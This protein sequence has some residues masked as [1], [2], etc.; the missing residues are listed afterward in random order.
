[1][2]LRWFVLLRFIQDWANQ[3]SEYKHVRKTN[4]DCEKYNNL[5][6]K[7][8]PSWIINVFV[9]MF[10]FPCLGVWFCLMY[11]IYETLW[12]LWF[13]Y[14]E[15]GFE[16]PAEVSWRRFVTVSGFVGEGLPQFFYRWLYCFVKE[17]R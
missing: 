5:L 6:L 13:G 16:N 9:L 8:T 3:V 7:D 15:A 17:M 2:C 14:S 12:T 10:M 11:D 1:M 4:G